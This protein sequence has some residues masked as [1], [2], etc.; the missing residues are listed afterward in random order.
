[1]QR[2]YTLTIQ[3]YTAPLHACRNETRRNDRY[4]PLFSAVV[5]DDYFNSLC[6]PPKGS[7]EMESRTRVG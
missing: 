2:Y 4:Y 7:P 3:Y 5:P 6:R 1:M